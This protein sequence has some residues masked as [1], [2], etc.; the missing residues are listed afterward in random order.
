LVKDKTAGR[1]TKDSE[2]DILSN[3]I[4]HNT[5]R[6]LTPMG[7]ARALARLKKWKGCPADELAKEF[8]ISKPT[9]SRAKSLLTLPRDILALVESGDVPASHA[10]EISRIPDRAVQRKLAHR[11]K[12]G[13]LTRNDVHKLV[14]DILRAD[15]RPGR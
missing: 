11:V 7:L 12:A 1:A 4:I 6:S 10:Y 9:I 15:S 3:Q 2:V 5:H 14:R 13:T 8:G